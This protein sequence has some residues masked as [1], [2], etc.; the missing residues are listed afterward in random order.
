MVIA[1]DMNM[2][3][4]IVDAHPA[5][6]T[7]P[8]CLSLH[9]ALF[10]RMFFSEKDNKRDGAYIGDERAAVKGRCLGAVDVFR[11]KYGMEKRYTCY[12]HRKVWGDGCTRVDM[13]LV[14]G[15]LW[16]DGR[17]IDTGIL[18]TLMDRGVSDH[19]PIWA[20]IAL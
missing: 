10:N 4:G 16:E 19:V 17:V 2:P 8:E 13:I 14:S 5:L 9:R 3:R 1:G 7:I 18:N 11:A 12:S 6:R 20:E 15:Q